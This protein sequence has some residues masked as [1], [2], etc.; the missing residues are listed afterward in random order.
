MNEQTRKALYAEAFTLMRRAEYLLD[1]MR[2][3]YEHSCK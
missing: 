3:K 1:T 2:L